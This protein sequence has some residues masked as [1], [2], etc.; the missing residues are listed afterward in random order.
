MIERCFCAMSQTGFD[1]GDPPHGV[2]PTY[3]YY[4]YY[5]MNQQVYQFASAISHTPLTLH[6]RPTSSSCTCAGC[7]AAIAEEKKREETYYV[8]ERGVPNPRNPLS[9]PDEPYPYDAAVLG[10]YTASLPGYKREKAVRLILLGREQPFLNVHGLA[11]LIHDASPASPYYNP[12]FDHNKGW[13][14]IITDFRTL[15]QIVDEES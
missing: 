12:H 11:Y 7:A 3:T 2:D 10:E 1:P 9:R 14:K 4:G 13:V 15:I 6:P 8:F 5:C